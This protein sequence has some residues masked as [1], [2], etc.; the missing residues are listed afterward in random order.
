MVM[1]PLWENRVSIRKLVLELR[2]FFLVVLKGE[3]IG[4]LD[5]SELESLDCMRG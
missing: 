5:N 2:L 4:T 3:E 1:S